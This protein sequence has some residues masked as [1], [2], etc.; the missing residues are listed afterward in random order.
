MTGTENNCI[1]WKQEV[2]AE[3]LIKYE[4]LLILKKLIKKNHATALLL[5]WHLRLHGGG[6]GDEDEKKKRDSKL[7]HY[8]PINYC[9]F[10]KLLLTFTLTYFNSEPRTTERVGHLLRILFPCL[11]GDNLKLK[12]WEQ[13]GRFGIKIGFF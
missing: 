6:R 7:T 13:C 11:T 2:A 1:I 12:L 3:Y 9:K 10:C 4:Y 8:C 5:V